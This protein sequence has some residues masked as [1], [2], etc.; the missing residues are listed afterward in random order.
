MKNDAFLYDALYQA[1]NNGQL[2]GN[3]LEQIQPSSLLESDYVKQ[4]APLVRRL[5]HQMLRN[6]FAAQCSTNCARMTGYRVRRERVSA[7]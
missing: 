7:T 4:Y 2:D 1:L 6:A 3:Q 5:A